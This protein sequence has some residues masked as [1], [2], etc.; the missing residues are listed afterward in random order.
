MNRRQ[1]L[2]TAPAL[3]AAPAAFAQA[4]Y[5]AR[6]VTIIVGYPTG[7]AN[8][9]IARSIGARLAAEYGQ[10]VIIENRAGAG[11]TL[12]G[13]VA[14]RAAPD[15]YTLF[16]CGGAHALAPALY[17]TLPYN[18]VEDFRALSQA[19]A[20]GYVLVLHPSVPQRS[21]AALIAYARANPGKLNFCSS[22]VGTPL[23]LSAVLF[24]QMT[25]T[26]MEHVPY[27]GDSD[28]IAALLGG[29]VELGF[30]SIAAAKVH[31]EAGRLIALAVTDD[32]P[33]PA[34]P[35]L[36]TLAASG[37]AGYRVTTWWG[38]LAPRNTP[39][40]IAQKLA[41][42]AQAAAQV[43]EVRQRFLDLGL[44]PVGS[45]AATFQQFI[46]SEVAGYARL[47][48]AAGVQPQ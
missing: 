11:G 41:A 45:D 13:G 20:S 4:P 15:G 42:S 17:K 19:A 1:A 26:R 5:P 40:A 23:H 35:S 6:A 10:P 38:L 25:N 43:P 39:D 27:Q 46:R 8:D 21:V 32:I 36:P 28:A 16:M 2:L 9:I 44:R 33:S 29:T 34:L 3:L 22:G 18:L 7:G 12:A 37:L 14:A 31:I 48:Q 47:A 30:M 24:Q